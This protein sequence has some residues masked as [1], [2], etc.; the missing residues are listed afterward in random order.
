MEFVFNTEKINEFGNMVS[1]FL[2]KNGVDGCTVTIQLSK[3]RLDKVNE[4][5]FYRLG[6]NEKEEKLEPSDKIEIKFPHNC[7]VVMTATDE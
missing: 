4:D 3:E 5:L 6:L 2:H 1:D 7:E